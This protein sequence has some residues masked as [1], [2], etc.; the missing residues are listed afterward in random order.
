MVANAGSASKPVPEKKNVPHDD[1][2]EVLGGIECIVW[3][4]LLEFAFLWCCRSVEQ[5]AQ[6]PPLPLCVFYLVEAQSVSVEVS[7]ACQICYL[8]L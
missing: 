8:T 7:R 5:M 2:K 4:Y 3:D 1:M 6:A